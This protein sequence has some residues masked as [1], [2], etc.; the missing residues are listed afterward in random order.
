MARHTAEDPTH[1]DGV[2]NGCSLDMVEVPEAQ[3]WGDIPKISSSLVPTK[4]QMVVESKV[5]GVGGSRDLGAP[6]TW[7]ESTTSGP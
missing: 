2:D 7:M 4:H 6:H 1:L 3:T 5:I